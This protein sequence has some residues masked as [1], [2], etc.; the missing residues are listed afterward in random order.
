MATGGT[1]EDGGWG[2]T[3]LGGRRMECSAGL[4]Q[5]RVR[6]FQTFYLAAGQPKT[7]VGWIP[8]SCVRIMRWTSAWAWVSWLSCQSPSNQSSRLFLVLLTI[9]GHLLIASFLARLVRRRLLGNYWGM[10][11]Q[12][13]LNTQF[14]LPSCHPS[15]LYFKP[16]Y[17]HWLHPT[18]AGW[19]GTTGNF[20]VRTS[21]LEVSEVIDIK[22]THITSFNKPQSSFQLASPA[23]WSSSLLASVAVVAPT[24]LSTF[25][26][27][28]AEHVFTTINNAMNTTIFFVQ[29]YSNIS[30]ELYNLTPTNFLK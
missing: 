3:T 24:E 23:S 13:A 12:V 30:S 2:S 29:K 9:I 17:F 15:W 1:V 27:P 10:W 5:D 28:G 25:Y 4:E 6:Q 11:V 16:E 19:L 26:G 21:S 8:T 14:T 20:V 18:V 22:Y 7:V